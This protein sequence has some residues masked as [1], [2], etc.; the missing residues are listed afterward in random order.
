MG[1]VASEAEAR[2]LGGREGMD[3][4]LAAAIEFFRTVDATAYLR[5]AESLLAKSRSA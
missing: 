4:N 3:V 2:L 5:E 1:A